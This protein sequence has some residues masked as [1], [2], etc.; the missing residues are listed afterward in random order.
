MPQ[1]VWKLDEKNEVV[2]KLGI[3]GRQQVLHNGKE[4][5]NQVRI[6]K[7]ENSIGF[8]LEEDK[9]AEVKIESKFY[10]QPEALL[11]L[12]GELVL[13]D[14]EQKKQKTC[15]KCKRQN[16]MG[17]ESCS[18]CGEKL[19]TAKEFLEK[20]DVGSA[21]SAII[22]LAVLFLAF[23]IVMYFL[24]KAQF[25]EALNQLKTHADSEQLQ[26]ISGKVYTVAEYRQLLETQPIMMLVANIILAIIMF[27]LSLWSKKSPLPAIIVAAAIY[28]VVQLGN[29]LVDPMA[30]SQ[31][32]VVKLLMIGLLARGIKAA[33]ANRI[34]SQKKE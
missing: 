3:W 14:L 9:R 10:A 24:Q 12:N 34:S 1:Q 28:V 2:V 29:I 8:D 5:Y 20:R 32:I 13:S 23:G 7:P 15:P 19:P 26:P 31:G 4:I 6:L 22:A 33:L 16:D 17:F 25:A 18:E 11:Y 27:L 21:T 30:M